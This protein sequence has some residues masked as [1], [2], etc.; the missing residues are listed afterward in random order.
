MLESIRGLLA[1]RGPA[2]VAAWLYGSVARGEDSPGSDLDIA[3]WF[4]RRRSQTTFG[5]I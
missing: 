1:K 5:R 2:I 4:A 3:S